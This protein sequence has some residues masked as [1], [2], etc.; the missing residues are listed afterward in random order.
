MGYCQGNFNSDNCACGGYTLDYG[1]FGFC[2]RFEPF[3]QPWTGGGRHFSFLNQ[4]AA[5]EA[6]FE[7]FC[8]AVTPLLS[9]NP[10][11]LKQLNRIREGFTAVMEEKM[12]NM[13]ASK[14]GLE[15]F[16]AEL[17]TQLLNL[18]IK[19]SVDYNMFFREL[20][21]LPNDISEL[22]ISFYQPPTDD[23]QMQWRQWL[24]KWA[25]QLS[26]KDISLKMNQVNPKYTWREWQIVPAYQ[27]A[28]E[29]NYTLVRD[30]QQVL[31]QPYSEQSPETEQNYYRLRPTALFAAGGRV[32]LQLFIMSMSAYPQLLYCYLYWLVLNDYAVKVLA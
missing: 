14:L 26:G 28:K 31:T 17:V 10:E 16:D 9:A 29:G 19:T 12:Q 15:K 27:E 25:S 32:S 5:A 18:M 3:F 1:P 8:T 23:L 2:E 21:K 7:M 30:L 20:S 13:W 4:P 22:A 24:D 11:G 6:N